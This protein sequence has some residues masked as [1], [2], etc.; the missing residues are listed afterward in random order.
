[1]NPIAGLIIILL[2][3]V[4][5]PIIVAAFLIMMTIAAMKKRGSIAK[6]AFTILLVYVLFTVGINIF[7]QYLPESNNYRNRKP[8]D[9]ISRT[10]YEN[11]Q[12]TEI[13]YEEKVITSK[14]VLNYR[15]L[16]YEENEDQLEKMLKAVNT[17]I[18]QEKISSKINITCCAAISGEGSEPVLSLENYS[19]AEQEKA[20][21]PS[22]QKLWIRGTTVSKTI[23]NIPE[24]YRDL[25]GIKYVEICD[26]MAAITERDNIDWYEYFPDLETLE[27]IPKETDN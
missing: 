7:A 21:Y 26:N 12:G 14:G 23:Y 24:T 13:Y 25:Q 6:K 22:L 5:G 19:D 9:S 11:L 4:A 16:F 1:M 17:I 10:I 20:D 27:I 3:C 2:D 18:Q 8:D 15:Y